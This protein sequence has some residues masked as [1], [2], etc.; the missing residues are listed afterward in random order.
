MKKNVL[1]VMCAVLALAMFVGVM[2][3]TSVSAAA[4]LKAP[5]ALKAAMVQ[6]AVGLMWD[7]VKGAK[8]YV[9]YRSVNDGKLKKVDTVDKNLYDEE[10]TF[11]EGTKLTYCVTAKNKK[12]ESEKSKTVKITFTAKDK[13]K[14]VRKAFAK[15]VKANGSE[16]PKGTYNLVSMDVTGDTTILGASYVEKQDSIGFTYIGGDDDCFYTIVLTYTPNTDPCIVYSAFDAE[17]NMVGTA[18]VFINPSKMTKKTKFTK[19]DAFVLEDDSDGAVD[20][21]AIINTGVQEILAYAKK[22]TGKID[23]VT[24]KK[25]G[26]KNYK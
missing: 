10:E 9:V 16:S 23:G 17:S 21:M 14:K 4:A 18:M 24:M 19:S 12:G 13:Y 5:K 15:Y 11:A 22:V 1:K 26:F 8:S 6:G 3:Q 2:P 20:H 7:E 25:L